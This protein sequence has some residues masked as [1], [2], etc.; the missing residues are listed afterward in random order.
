MKKKA[1]FKNRV[2][3]KW[4]RFC[5]GFL[6][7][8]VYRKKTRYY[9]QSN[10]EDYL[11]D[12]V[13]TPYCVVRKVFKHVKKQN[14]SFV[15]VGCGSGRVICWV[16]KKGLFKSY[17]GIEINKKAYS[18]ALQNTYKSKNTSVLNDD[19]FAI[20]LDSFDCFYMWKPMKKEKWIEFIEKIPISISKKQLI[21]V[22]DFDVFEYM[23]NN[24]QWR[25]VLRKSFKS[26]YGV[27]IDSFKTMYSIW[28]TSI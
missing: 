27:K 2:N 20:N 5:D 1:S 13:S 10:K 6:D 7:I 21:L 11:T 15:D 16:A 18:L 25:M 3:N 12:V 19:A 14:T 8:F 26:I 4:I 23:S 24:K 9:E 28:E 17:F 22:N